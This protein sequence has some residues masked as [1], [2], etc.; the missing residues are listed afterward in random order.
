MKGG[1]VRNRGGKICR[2]QR[3]ERGG[4]KFQVK[5]KKKGGVEGGFN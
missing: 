1:G 5:G 3:G 4:K 2:K